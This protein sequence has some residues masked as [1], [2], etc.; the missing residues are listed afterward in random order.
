MN[1]CA[2]LLVTADSLAVHKMLQDERV[3][4]DGR[5]VADLDVIGPQR[6]HTTGPLGDSSG[7]GGAGAL[8]PSGHF[9]V[10][11]AIRRRLVDHQVCF[12]YL[13]HMHIAKF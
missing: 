5:P 4:Q 6:Y 12:S 11:T 1:T 3:K 8:A 13:G 2:Q 9:A 10:P 7:W